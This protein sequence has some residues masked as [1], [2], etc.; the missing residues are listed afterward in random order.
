MHITL[1][2]IRAHTEGGVKLGQKHE[3]SL[4]QDLRPF[5]IQSH[6]GSSLQ[7]NVSNNVL[8]PDAFK[9]GNLSLHLFL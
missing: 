1:A 8:F 5:I 6:A 9:H 4:E 7:C 2:H 3:V